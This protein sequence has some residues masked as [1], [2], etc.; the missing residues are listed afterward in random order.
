M[1]TNIKQKDICKCIPV[2]ELISRNFYTPNIVDIGEEKVLLYIPKLPVNINCEFDYI[3]KKRK[4]VD[5]LKTY[6]RVLEANKI[7]TTKL[8][9]E[10]TNLFYKHDPLSKQTAWLI[11][12][13]LVNIYLLH[14]DNAIKEKGL[15]YTIQGRPFLKITANQE[16][17]AGLKEV[18]LNTVFISVENYL[19]K[20]IL[21]TKH[22]WKEFANWFLTN[23]IVMAIEMVEN[24][25]SKEA[26]D[27]MSKE[28]RVEIL[29]G[30]VFK[31]NSLFIERYRYLV[32][33][34]VQ[35][36]ARAIVRNIDSAK[37]SMEQLEIIF[38]FRALER[39]KQDVK[40][41]LQIDK[42]VKSPSSR[43]L[44]GVGNCLLYYRF[45]EALA[46]SDFTIPEGE[47]WPSANLTTGNRKL[48]AIVQLRPDPAD[49]EPH[50][51]NT[52]IIAWQERMRQ[53]V[54]A[55]DDVTADVMDIVS[56]IWLK[57][58]SHYEDIATVTA[59]DI[60]GFRGL[61]PQKNGA[62]RRGGYKGEWRQEI[63]RH[64]AILANTWIVVTE[65]DVT[66]EVEGKK[67]RQRKRV[68]WQGESKAWVVDSNFEQAA[69]E[70]KNSYV[71][72]VRP[73]DVFSKFLFGAGRQ[74][75][76]IS[77][78]AVE[79]H[80]IN[81]QWE[82]RLTRYLTWQWRNR[83]GEGA[84]LA[85]FNI[86][87]LMNAVNKEISKHNPIQTKGRLEKALDTLQQ[88]H[89]ITGWQYES[90]NEDNVGLKGWWKEWLKWKVIIEPPQDIMDHYGKI[91][92]PRIKKR[93]AH[94]T[95]YQEQTST[96][97]G[98]IVK[99]AR[100]QM[101]LSQMQAAEEI[102]VNQ[103]TMSRLER[104]ELTDGRTRYLL[105]KWLGGKITS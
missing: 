61:K 66:E 44:L 6:Q 92:K 43:S 1:D 78:K 76:L 65:M 39:K 72:R 46:I 104:G 101:G 67:G 24:N 87:T 70:G 34:Y 25:F 21:G 93:E 81:Q 69:M 100:L 94:S 98:P 91:R 32:V 55:M 48:R 49:I 4:T 53:N 58:A 71:W 74:T 89:I 50:L 27:S 79:Y 90:V 8:L 14:L 103:S 102:G 64:I 2:E 26:L 22:V 47:K 12:P 88:D 80:P 38:G 9:N 97:M 19:K 68:K 16:S 40:I 99:K 73:G 3:N 11:T 37:L 83:Q 33:M 84:Y 41:S 35:D 60:L 36:L 7:I 51:S 42:S 30:Y 95:G 54:M 59:D 56:A 62:G 82:K 57:Q 5:A 18:Y 63:A 28:Q 52:E 31:N 13:Y 105:K 17:D 15:N 45:R 23:L 29:N 75:A 20:S 85:P 10:W 96:F 86:E 77:Q